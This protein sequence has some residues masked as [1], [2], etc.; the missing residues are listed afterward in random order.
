M[1]K[2]ALF[3]LILALFLSGRAG[4]QLT[5]YA[6]PGLDERP[7]SFIPLDLTFRNEKGEPVVLKKFI[8]RPTVLML[9]Y[10]SCSH[11]CPQF[12]GG[13]ADSLAGLLL[14]PARDYRVLTV[15]FD[16]TDRPMDA[17]ELKKN[18]IKA[19]GRP[20]PEDTW[21][22]L[23][24]DQD[25]IMRLSDAV[26]VRFTRAGHGFV[27]PEVLIFL[28]PEGK[29][30]RYL[31]APKYSYGLPSPMTFS[32][33]DLKTAFSDA[34]DGKVFASGKG[35][36]PLFCFLH[37]PANQELFFNM[38]KV[39]GALTLL[40]LFLLFVYLRSGKKSTP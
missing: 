23:T 10:Y 17:R 13:F 3:A 22:F 1:K 32:A 6:E 11:I 34:S 18:Y 33:V 5:G 37:E 8:D 7:G 29:I 25:N 30:T 9:V 40:G 38:L 36:T 20:F 39:T 14:D 26:G 12:L 2:T 35:V 27:H 21:H 24:G 16:E 4:A 15:S 31:Q 28:S 19:I